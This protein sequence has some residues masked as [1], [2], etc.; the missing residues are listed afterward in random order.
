MKF[1][2]RAE[3][4]RC[5]RKCHGCPHGPYW[6]GYYREGKRLRKRYFG[7]VDPRI[8]DYAYQAKVDPRESIFNRE[9]ASETLA[10]NILGVRISDDYDTVRHVW[11]RICLTDHP[12]RGG[13]CGEFQVKEAA[14]SYLKA[15]RGWK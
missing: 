12:D 3:Y 10:C 2:F 1:T 4:I 5:G 13:D 9:L 8:K 15:L 11:V 7:K 6:Y 14:W